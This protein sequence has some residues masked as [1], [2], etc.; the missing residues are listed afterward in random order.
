MANRREL[1]KKLYFEDLLSER[2]VAEKIGVSRSTIKS[3]KLAITAI[4]GREYKGA[5]TDSLIGKILRID[6]MSIKQLQKM[7][8][9]AEDVMMKT[10]MIN[11]L[12]RTN[13]ELFD[14]LAR[15]GILATTDNK[16]ELSTD[17]SIRFEMIV[18]EKD[19]DE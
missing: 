13:K 17:K 16:L 15:L 2:K 18:K 11:E 10:R 7:L 19:K 14:K 3:D 4:W 12:T 6:T 5:K 9:D 1:V 8:K